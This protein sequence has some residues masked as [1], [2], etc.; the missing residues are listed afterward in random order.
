MKNLKLSALLNALGTAVYIAIVALVMQNGERIFGKTD[1]MTGPIAILLLFVLSATITSALVLG[2]P[3][4]YYL[5]N[6]KTE[7]V[8][9]FFYTIGWLFVLTALVFISQIFI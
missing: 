6:K 7:A 1:N 9:L 3:I 2:K 8:K 4:L 5:E